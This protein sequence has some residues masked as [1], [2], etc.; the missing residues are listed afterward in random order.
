M[1]SFDELFDKI[2]KKYKKDS[3]SND[4]DG[5]ESSSSFDDLFDRIDSRYKKKSSSA[6]EVAQQIPIGLG[7]GALSTYGNLL[8]MAG[9]NPKQG[10]TPTQEQRY[11]REAEGSPEDLAWSIGDDLAPEYSGRLPTSE[12]ID[13]FS[14]LLGIPEAETSAGKIAGRGSEAVGGALSLGGAGGPLGTALAGAGGATGQLVREEGGPEWLAQAADIGINFSNLPKAILSKTLRPSSKQKQIV[15]FLKSK[16]MSDKNITPIIQD[17]K[18]LALF[19]KA[20][21]K[22]DKKEPWLKAI[23][24]DLGNIFDGIREEGR[25]AGNLTGTSLRKF[26]D[27]FYDKL[28][29]VPRMYRGLIKKEVEDLFNNPINFTE[30]HD[31]NK[32]VNAI[33]GDVSGGKAAVGLL[34]EPIEKAQQSMNPSL[35]KELKMTNKAYAGLSEFTNK[36]TKK[37]WENLMNMGEMGGIT[38]G[39]LMMNPL[40]LKPGVALAGARIGSRQALSNPRLQ[41]M[42]LKLKDAF[43]KNDIAK[44]LRLASELN[45]ELGNGEEE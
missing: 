5:E 3:G 24:G 38:Y 28:D 16:G 26:E 10:L 7:K 42:H 31:F 35:Y 8:E 15:D 2:D 12:D 40:L 20:A 45:K 41:G 13:N 37:N 4:G 36:M 33:V 29:K 9:I 11:R 25:Q 34:K 18:K 19:S 1:S 14:R 22:Y 43:L 32:A 6:K 21:L 17:K 44:T 23:Q 27:S 30:L 39:L